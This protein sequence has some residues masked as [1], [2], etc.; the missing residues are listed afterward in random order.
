VIDLNDLG[1]V[2][3]PAGG[4]WTLTT[5][6]ALSADGWVSGE[7]TFDPDGGGP[8]AGYTRLWVAQVG[9]GGT[10]KNVTGGTWG[11]GPNW[12]TGTPATQVGYAQF[13]MPSTYT[14]TL[15]RDECTRTISVDFG[16]V[17]FDCNGHT[18]TSESGLNIA[19][20]ATLKGTGTII[21]DITNAGIIAPGNS[22]GMLNINGSL[23]NNNKLEFE[24]ANLSS[25]DKINVTGAFISGG[26]IAL[27]L[28]GGYVPADGDIFNLMSFDSFADSGYVFDFSQAGLP[29]DLQW[30]TATFATT[31][32]ISVVPEPCTLVLL[33]VAGLGLLICVWR[34]RN[35]LRG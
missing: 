30:D 21:S 5:A 3:V 8:L 11:R 7:G 23:T 32:S 15:D 26:T 18:L 9:L 14:V 25:H 1:V 10:W 6:K 22:P 16:I 34:G 28:S 35:Q 29:A 12:T 27:K 4:T 2:P 13:T 24:I 20:G 19:N 31:G 17:T 33:G